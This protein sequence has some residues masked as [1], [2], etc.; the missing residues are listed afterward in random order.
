M[1]THIG[2][3][4]ATDVPPSAAA[5]AGSPRR[6]PAVVSLAAASFVDRGEDQT[7]SILWPQ[8]HLSLGASVGAL[9]PILGLSKLVSTVMLPLWGYASDRWS[10]RLLLVLFTGLWGVW[11]MAIG[12]VDSLPQLMAVRL[13]S[14]LGLG[15][16]PPAAFSLIGDLYPSTARGRAAGIIQGIGLLG[17]IIAFG[18]LPALA[19][20]SPDAWRLGFVL[21]GL[22]S[23]CT[24]ILLFVCVREPAR[25]AGEPELHGVINRPATVPARTTWADL[26]VLASIPSWRL[27]LANETVRSLGQSVFVGWLFT[28]LLGLGLGPVSVV[29]ASLSSIGII[30]GNVL[31]GWLGDRLDQRYPRSGRL[32]LMFGGMLV[33]LPTTLLFLASGGDNLPRLVGYGMVSGLAGA[34]TVVGWPIGQAIVPPEVRGSGRALIDMLAGAAGALA[35]ALSGPLADRVGIAPMLLMLVPVPIAL[36]L[37]LWVPMFRTY[38]RDRQALQQELARRRAAVVDSN[39]R[40]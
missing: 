13:I 31:F 5:R 29:V 2:E 14:S 15:V 23:F 38:P 20:H 36:S 30:G 12:L 1:T 7:L 40:D 27:L 4:I 6:W 16:F 10:R 26:R 8:I 28:W 18:V 35:L 19:A 17:T 21:M 34:A 37:L 39:P 24:G 9:G 32:A 33:A 3:R 11:T 22:A 25:G